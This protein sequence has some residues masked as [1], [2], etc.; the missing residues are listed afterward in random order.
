MSF[1][2]LLLNLY[3]FNYVGCKAPGIQPLTRYQTHIQALNQV[4]V[5][6]ENDVLRVSLPGSPVCEYVNVK[7]RVKFNVSYKGAVTELRLLDV[8]PNA[9]AAV[10]IAKVL[11]HAHIKPEMWGLDDI[12]VQIILLMY[13]VIKE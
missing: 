1:W 4:A 6:F 12:E 10:A 2:L 7:A 13:Q 9:R 8:Q 5:P 3:P 11:R